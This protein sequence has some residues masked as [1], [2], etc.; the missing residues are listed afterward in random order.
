MIPPTVH[1]IKVSAVPSRNRNSLEIPGNQRSTHARI[2][3]G[4][5]AQDY[6]FLGNKPNPTQKGFQTGS[7]THSH[8]EI[9][10]A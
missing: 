9:V 7:P 3:K 10:R 4:E 8:V 1:G 2:H 6:W 5:D